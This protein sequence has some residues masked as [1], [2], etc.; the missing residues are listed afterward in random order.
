MYYSAEM[1]EG[2]FL[3][4][5]RNSKSPEKLRKSLAEQMNDSNPD[6]GIDY[7]EVSL[8]ELLDCLECTLYRHEEPIPDNFLID[9]NHLELTEN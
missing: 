6:D 3:Y 2:D 9:N 5:G 8:T 1:N 7:E 4:T